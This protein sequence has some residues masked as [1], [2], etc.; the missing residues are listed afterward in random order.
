M[1]IEEY[2]KVRD[3]LEKVTET[4]IQSFDK[5]IEEIKNLKD[6]NETL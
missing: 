1:T 2:K 4:I 5:F 6:N 3:E